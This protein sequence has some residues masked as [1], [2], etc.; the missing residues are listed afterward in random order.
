MNKIF[1][2]NLLMFLI[3]AFIGCKNKLEDK[4]LNI[5]WLVA[6]DLSP[7]YLSAYGDLTSPTPN[8]DKLASEGVVYD[9]SLIHI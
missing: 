6:E 8:L 7:N 1:K 3:L 4:N 2:I 9:L 5:L